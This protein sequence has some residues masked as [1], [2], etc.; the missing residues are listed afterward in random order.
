MFHLEYFFLKLQHVLC[1]F[2]LFF[3]FINI[4]FNIS[5]FPDFFHKY[6]AIRFHIFRNTI[7]KKELILDLSERE[8]VLKNCYQF[9]KLNGGPV[10]IPA[11]LELMTTAS[12][13][14]KALEECVCQAKAWIR[15]CGGGSGVGQ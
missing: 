2:A 14:V 6:L 5:R 4:C 9:K 10:T 11:L 1:P 12:T 8:R 7:F 3:L 13:K 15:L